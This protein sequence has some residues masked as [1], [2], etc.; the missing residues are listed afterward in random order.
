[1]TAPRAP[2][3]H[4]EP[5]LEGLFAAVLGELGQQLKRDTGLHRVVNAN[6]SRAPVAQR[7][8]PDLHSATP[9]MYDV[10]VA[11]V[12]SAVCPALRVQTPELPSWLHLEARFRVPAT[13]LDA[14]VARHR[15][16]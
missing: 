8:G 6:A 9:M 13:L 10:M 14:T 5:E 1:M 7:R 11:T 3:D 2:H 12:V 4:V 16:H 15:V